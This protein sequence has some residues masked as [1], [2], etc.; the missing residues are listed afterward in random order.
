MG[1]FANSLHI[2]CDDAGDV[3]DSIQRALRDGG[4]ETTDELLDEEAASGLSPTLRGLRVS[5]AHEGWVGLLDSDLIHASSL[6][7]DLSR[8]LETCAIQFMVND[9][10]SWHYLLW[11]HGRQVDEFDSSG[12]LTG[13]PE[14]DEQLAGMADMISG[15]GLADFEERLRE[16]EQEMWRNLPPEIREIQ[17]RIQEGTATPEDM[18]AFG[19]WYQQ[20][21]GDLMG[22]LNEMLPG[23]QPF[24]ERQPLSETELRAHAE[25]LRPVLP[26]AASPERLLEALGRQAVFAEETLEQFLQ[27][28]GI[29]PLFAYLSYP[30][31]S[32]YTD[33]ELLGGEVRL[34]ADLRFSNGSSAV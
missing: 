24:G 14:M 23:V 12:G 32:E 28:V 18:H 3:V 1:S 8:R 5:E 30:Y 25:K 27:V 17:Q 31:L 10:D 2:R 9:S 15:G 22:N 34:V 20:M 29:Q 33:S 26:P 6:A 19:E 7:E 21:A 16:A 4:Y 11:R 13:S